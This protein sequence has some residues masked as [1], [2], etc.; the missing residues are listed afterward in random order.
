[1]NVSEEE[2]RICLLKSIYEIDL[3]NNEITDNVISHHIEVATPK[4]HILPIAMLLA[5]KKF[6][7]QT[8]KEALKKEPV[9]RN[10]IKNL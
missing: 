9:L 1:M 5:S 8:A 7:I 2:S 10:I 3:I 6:N 4:P